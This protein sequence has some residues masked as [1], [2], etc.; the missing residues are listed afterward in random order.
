MTVNTFFEQEKS[1]ALFG[2]GR[3]GGGIARRLVEKRWRVIGWNRTSKVAAD[4]AR[5][6][7]IPVQTICEAIELLPTPRVLWIMV[8]AGQ[9]FDDLC[10]GE[11]GVLA[12]CQPGDVIIEGGNSFYKDSQR[13]AKMVME[14]GVHFIDVGVSGGPDGARNGPCL[15]IG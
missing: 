6:G 15:M 12:L 5:E 8:P 3:M 13:R 1:I 11:E 7:V 14:R 10:F 9:A 2:L 4:Y